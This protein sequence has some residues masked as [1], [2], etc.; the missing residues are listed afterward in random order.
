M[1]DESLRK[2]ELLLSQAVDM[3]RISGISHQEL[4]NALQLLME[5]FTKPP[6]R[7]G[8]EPFRYDL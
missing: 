1:R 5:A 7:P 4:L 2:I 6:P 8:I 3:A